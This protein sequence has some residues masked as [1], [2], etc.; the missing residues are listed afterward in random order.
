[1]L[2]RSG[3][4]PYANLSIQQVQPTLTGKSAKKNSSKAVVLFQI[5]PSTGIAHE[6]YRLQVSPDT[7]SLVASTE[8]G[9]HN[10]KETLLQLARYNNGQIPVC[11]INDAPRF[12]WR[13]FML[14]E[15]R[16]F[17]GK[18]KVKQYLDLM[19]Q[20][21][22]NVFHWHLTDEPDRKSVV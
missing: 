9:L 6:G 2:F 14:D 8:A 16:H 1:M 13:G 7:L 22:L 21:R 10:G 4:H 19:A 17:F 15:S 20:L 12:E 3:N 5:D 11:T 18:E